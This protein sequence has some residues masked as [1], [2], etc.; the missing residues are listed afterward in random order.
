MRDLI[1]IEKKKIHFYPMLFDFEV[2]ILSKQKNV[3]QNDFSSYEI[4]RK[5]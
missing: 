5:I 3:I 4:M 1:R 2:R